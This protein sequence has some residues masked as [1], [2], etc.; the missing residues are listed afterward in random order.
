MN[1]GVTR[2]RK[3]GRRTD[4]FLAQTL[5]P[6][7]LGR[8][9]EIELAGLCQA[10]FEIEVC[11]DGPSGGRVKTGRQVII[12]PVVDAKVEIEGVDALSR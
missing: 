9:L 11:V 12:Q 7:P 2:E 3:P 10:S 4:P 1:L 8:E 6:V 5:G